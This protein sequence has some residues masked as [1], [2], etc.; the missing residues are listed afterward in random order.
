MK[1][2][3]LFF[4]ISLTLLLTACSFSLAE[5]IKPPAGYQPPP[6]MQAPVASVTS[7][8]LFPLLPP[9]PSKGEAIYAEKCAACHG[10]LGL[11]DGE[12]GSQLPNPVPAI[13]SPQVARQAAPSDWFQIVSQGNLERFMPPFPS[14]TDRQRW[15]V[16]A[17]V[18]SLSATLDMSQS[19]EVYQANCAGC[20]GEAGK[21][22]GPAAAGLSAT[23]VDFTN[24]EYMA[25]KSAQALYQ[26]ISSGAGQAM[27]AFE[28]SLDEAQRWAV[29]DY[30]RS[31]TFAS[32][33][34]QAG[35][36]AQETPGAAIT[37]SGEITSTLAVSESLSLGSVSGQVV[38]ASGGAV[39]AGLT[40]S[41]L[42]FN[43][44][45]VVISDTVKLDDQGKYLFQNVDMPEGLIFLTTV[46]FDG[47]TYGSEAVTIEQAGQTLDLPIEVYATTTDAS[48]LS[49]DR[50]HFFF[51]LI[52][53]EN[54]RVV[55]LYIIS[56][57]GAETLVSPAEGQPV[58]TFSLPAEAS[59]LEFQEGEL[60]DRFV[61]TVDGFGDTV[62][63][64]PGSGSYQVLFSYEIPYKRKL[65]LVRPV[66]LDT[67]AVVILVPEDGISV[68]GATLEDA[69]V[70]DVQGVAYHLYNGSGMR[71]GESLELTISGSQSLQI[72]SSSSSLLIGLA[73]LG[74]VLIVAGL[75]LSRR[76]RM[77]DVQVDDGAVDEEQGAES[78]ENAET[79]MDAILALDDLYQE[80]QLPE[81]AYHQRRSELKARLSEL[82]DQS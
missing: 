74:V 3:R 62:P 30:L 58:I 31:L 75:W 59:N 79:V 70:R 15:D 81:E 41:L 49:V 77:A 67:N 38:S 82:L 54:L 26:A 6:E 28:G 19:A 53:A 44:M 72:P 11:G 66:N 43:H 5:D 47:I 20:H 63:V 37:P 13:G 36:E 39:P 56:N 1:L 8:P 2:T 52:D 73:A 9:D 40:V 12:Q 34:A 14:L 57:P 45:Q 50:L 25:G 71:A 21:G 7:G 80:G 55:E 48:V 61:K 22:D 10:E 24:Q 33:A 29:T 68:K 46:E 23:P 32:A 64:R 16:V 76:S 65:E 69:G 51:E 27:P 4:F 35:L 42:G 78:G 18:L 17:Y 60:G